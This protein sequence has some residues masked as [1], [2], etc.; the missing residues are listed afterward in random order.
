MNLLQFLVACFGTYGV[1]Q[2]I[3]HYDGPFD[4]FYKLRS[5]FKVFRCYV[6]TSV[7][8]GMIATIALLHSYLFVDVIIF[9]AIGV[10]GGA[11]VIH[12]LFNRWL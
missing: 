5:K 11:F 7:W 1:S 10:I 6:C 8:I 4:I 2:I 12:E 9:W 3:T